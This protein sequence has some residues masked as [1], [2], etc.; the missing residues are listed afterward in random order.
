MKIVLSLSFLLLCAI[1]CNKLMA[2]TNFVSQNLNDIYSKLPLD[3]KSKLTS[4]GDVKICKLADE[5]VPIKIKYNSIGE[6]VHLGIAIFNYEDN[7]VYPSSLLAFIERYSLSFFTTNDLA[8]INKSNQENKISIRINNKNISGID[9]TNIS[10][11]KEFFS[12]ENPKTNVQYNDKQFLVTIISNQ[13]SFEILFPA[14]YELVSGMDKSEFGLE[15]Q[16][17]LTSIV[18][19]F[20]PLQV[21]K[22]QE[23]LSTYI[24]NLFINKKD[25]YFK[26][27]SADTFYKC[28][29]S[30]Y[31][32]PVQGEQNMLEAIQNNFLMPIAPD[33]IQLQIKQKLYGNKQLDYI[34][35]LRQFIEYF[36]QDHKLYFGF[37]NDNKEEIEGTLIIVNEKLNYIN[38]LH[39]NIK[40]SEFFSQKQSILKGR[41]FTN[42]PSD[43]IKNI[44]AEFK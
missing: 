39:V 9:N 11:I 32:I 33:R 40:S 6:V 8:Q 15:I 2:Q 37:E 30:N 31:C 44:F 21:S 42:I 28:P 36:L 22:K 16:K 25:E 3:C 34:V 27:I 23:E 35:T 24:N 43:N 29:N 1:D 26:N 7:L 13:N 17:R 19:P 38:L 10:Q 14:N 20:S 41:F 12:E 5:T 18:S 4:Y